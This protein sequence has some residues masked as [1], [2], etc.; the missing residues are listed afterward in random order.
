M[1]PT[2]TVKDIRL[3]E[4]HAQFAHPFRFG[5][6]TVTGTAQAFVHVDIEVDGEQVEG[7]AAELMVPKWFDK[8]PALTIEGAVEQL[9]TSLLLARDIYLDQK[10]PMSAFALHAAVYPKQIRAGAAA[11]LPQLAAVFGPAEIDKAILDALL[12]ALGMDVFEGLARNVMGL[13]ARLT[14]DL[15]QDAIRKV[16]AGGQ[17]PDRIAVRHTVGMVDPAE[18]LDAVVREQGCRYF[19]IKLRGDPERDIAR[20]EE[21][22]AMLDPLGVDYRATLDANEQYADPAQL[23][24]L[25]ELL[26]AAPR[27]AAFQQRML[28]IE[29]PLPRELTWK[30][31]LGAVGERVN[32]I[33]D[34]ADD[35]YDTFPRALA[36]G[37]RGI[38]SKCC[39]GLYKSILNTARAKARPGCFIS[40]EDLTSQAGLAVQ[41]DTALVAFLGCTHV[42][43]NGHHY[44]DGFDGAPRAEGEAFLAAHPDF[45][46]EHNGSIRLH[47]EDGMLAIGSLAVPGF[48][49]GVPPDAIAQTSIID[50]KT[51]EFTT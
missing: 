11:G 19:K 23:L 51:Q 35:G 17:R 18:T 36:L 10:K 21:L 15:D 4:R 30:T 22:A 50:I 13:D 37:Y 27:L 25:V 1:T 48:A 46:R 32:V 8:N 12:R 45:Y 40:A 5:D 7:A 33:I 3:T 34:E 29:Q 24:K 42:E 9:R 6:V 44:G 43:R 2:L 26:Q 14:P 20:L 38:S 41:Q 39:K 16:L 49:C 31:P 28:Y 47:I